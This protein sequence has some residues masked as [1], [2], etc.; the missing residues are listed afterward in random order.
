MTSPTSLPP[1]LLPSCS[2]EYLEY[3]GNNLRNSLAQAIA[4][5]WAL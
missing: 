2:Q 1:E 4:L 5:W 3:H